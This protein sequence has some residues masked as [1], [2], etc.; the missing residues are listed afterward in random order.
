V[1][2]EKKCAKC[3]LVRALSDFY[4][5]SKRQK[6]DGLR[7][8]CKECCSSS[9]KA[10]HGKHKEKRKAVREFTKGGGILSGTAIVKNV[11]AGRITITPFREEYVNPSSL[12]LTLGGTVIEYELPD[13]GVLDS[14]DPPRTVTYEIPSE[15]L[16]LHPGRAYLMHT[17]ESVHTKDFISVLD[18]KSSLGRLFI[19]V[20]VTAGYIDPGFNGQVTL[21]VTVTHP[22][23]V[24]PGMRFCQIRFHTIVGKKDLYSGNYTGKDAEGPI[25]SKAWK[26]IKDDGLLGKA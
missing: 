7:V 16:V 3:G 6:F 8:Y 23:K 18:G 4:L 14:K 19:S 11:K 21:E 24:Y 20:H 1:P 25:A 26:Q 2:S 22:V 9:N 13:T 10:S 15:G 5:D 17:H 12:D